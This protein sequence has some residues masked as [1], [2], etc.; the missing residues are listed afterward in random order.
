MSDVPKDSRSAWPDG[1][2]PWGRY[3]LLGIGVAIATFAADQIHKYWMIEIYRIGERGRV[4]VTSFFDLVMLWNRGISY[5]LLPQHSDA[6]RILL[7]VLALLAVFALLLWMGNTT[8]R[9]VSISLGLIIGGALGN[10]ADRLIYGAVADFF[11]F[12]YAG[13]YWYVF[14][15]AD[16]AITA[17]VIGLVLDWLR[18]SHTNVPKSV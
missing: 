12:H 17:G 5:G 7:V 16:V 6:G 15:I 1:I 10:L 2:W 18:P 3:S 14:N 11:S 9:L 8:A 13:F 4:T